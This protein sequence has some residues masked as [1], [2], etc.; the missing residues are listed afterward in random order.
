MPAHLRTAISSCLT[1]VLVAILGCGLA[2]KQTFSQGHSQTPPGLPGPPPGAQPGMGMGGLNPGGQAPRPWVPGQAAPGA[3]GPAQE[4][5]A[6]DPVK[7]PDNFSLPA[8]KDPVMELD[9]PPVLQEEIDKLKGGVGKYQTVLRTARSTEP[10][11]VLIRNGIRYRLGLM[12]LLANRQKLSALHG[13]LL[14]DLDSAAQ[15]PDIPKPAEV[16]AFRQMVL[17]EVISQVVPLLTTQNFYVRLHLVILLGELNLTEETTKMV[18]KVEAFVPAAEPL[19]QVITDPNQPEAV[20]VAAVNGLVRILKLGNPPVLVRTKI[21]EG[22]VAELKNKK[23]HPWYQMRLAGALGSVDIDLDQARK[24]PFVVDILKLVM[25]DDERTWSVRAEA[26]KSLGRVPL[27]PAVD[28]PSVTRAVAAFAL[29]LATAA[30]QSPQQKPDD[31]KWRG[32]FIKLYLAFQPLDANDLMAN[33]TAKA[34]LLNNPAAAAKAA[35]DL[36]VPLVAAILHGQRLTA[37][38][39]SAL[40]TYVSPSPPEKNPAQAANEQKN[41]PPVSKGDEAP[42]PMTVGADGPKKTDTTTNSP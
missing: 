14:R 18:P 24:Q 9:R 36:I 30:Q 33:K 31:P 6:P 26:A 23:A 4:I 40:Q 29:K 37:Q 8:S 2:Q 12:C 21:A 20:K 13:D 42:A 15:A 34:G 41:V 22:L 7:L 5:K 27:P 1:C 10:D 11:K 28:P 32:E 25:A 19:V 17:Q 3:K 35:Y 16:K 39:V 38:Q